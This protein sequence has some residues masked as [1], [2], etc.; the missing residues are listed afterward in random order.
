M[1]DLAMRPAAAPE[2]PEVLRIHSVDIEATRDLLNRFYYPIAVGAPDGAEG[3]SLDF[4]VIQLGPLTVGQL[5]FGGPTAL[6]ASELDGYHVTL[7]TAGR[8]L[9]RQAGHEVV[10]TPQTAAVF[11]PGDP[12]YTLHDA[13]SAEL[14]IKIDRYALEAELAALLG[15]EVRGTIDLHASLDLRDGPGQSFRRMVCLLRDELPYAESLIR[16]PVIAAQVRQSVL[17]GLLLCLPHRYRNE[18]TAPA[19]PGTPRAIRRVV[20]AIQEEPERP[21]T[22]ADLAGIAGVSVRSL[23]EGFRRHVGCTPMSYLQQVRM[24]RVHEALRN[25]DPTRVTVATVAHRWGFA[26][27]GRFASSYRA[28]FGVSPSETLR[29]S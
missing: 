22:V 5:R 12:V 29:G 11:R 1:T 3:F 7:P 18:L 23:Q 8:A 10:A 19:R 21:F 15:R 20:S 25:A 16:Q 13:H 28:R 27:L 2:Q 4:E 14:D 26:H 9:T 24:A 6:I 17:N